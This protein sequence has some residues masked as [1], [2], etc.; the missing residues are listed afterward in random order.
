[1][2]AIIRFSVPDLKK[3]M[4]ENNIK[5]ATTMNKP[6]ILKLLRERD[7]VPAEALIPT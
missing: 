2:P 1:M 7:L 6:E 5:G 3:I 4:K